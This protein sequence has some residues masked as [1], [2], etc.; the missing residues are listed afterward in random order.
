MCWQET[1]VATATKFA[2]SHPAAQTGKENKLVRKLTQPIREFFRHRTENWTTLSEIM[3][4]SMAVLV[5]I[6]TG[7]LAAILIWTLDLIGE[8]AFWLYSVITD[9]FGL[10]LGLA[11]GGLVVGYVV[12]RWAPEAGGHGVPEVIKSVALRGGYMRG[13]LAPIKLVLSSITIGMGGSAGRE[14]PIVQIGAAFGSWLGRRANFSGDRLRILV[15]CGSAAGISAVFNAPIAGAMF[16]LEVIVRRFTIANF[17]AVVLSAVFG[18]IVVSQVV[19]TQPAFPVPAYEFTHLGE[20]PIYAV[21]GLLAALWAALF[22]RVFTLGER[23]FASLKMPLALKAALGMVL[24]G[25]LA[26]LLPEREILG[27][28]LE[29]IG[30]TI[31]DN[32]VLPWQQLV[33]LLV[34]KMLATT[35]TLGSGNSGGV[36]APNLFM[37]AALGGLVGAGANML[38]PTVAVNPGAYAL[39]GMAAVLA[40]AERAPITG[41]LLVFEMSGDYQLILPLMLTTVLAA[42]TVELM[43]RGSI[44]TSELGLE[45]IRLRR[46]RDEAVLDSITVAEVMTPSLE[47]VPSNMTLEEFGRQLR[48]THH[49]GLPMIDDGRLT[50]VVTIGD[51]DRAM[52]NDLPGD[53]AVR[54][55]ATPR[56]RLIT[57]S[58]TDSIGE[59]MRL[60]GRNGFGRIP[61]VDQ[62]NPDTFLGMVR[63]EDVIN[64]YDIALTRRAELKKRAAETEARHP[65]SAVFVELT[66]TDE[67]AAC[68]QTIQRLAGCLPQDCVLVAVR[69]GGRLL[70]PHGDTRLQP[71]D[72]VTALV[73]EH[74]R[75]TLSE[76]LGQPVVSSDMVTG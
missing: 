10:L 62:E 15:A 25:L 56:S 27:S 21:L 23:T 34:L 11:A 63:R 20:L 41:I 54:E 30:E 12:E 67:C 52:Q 37:G 17:G 50:G 18:S 74:D 45:G 73:A 36:F 76:C 16:A 65:D 71:G 75:D 6:G 43:S 57:V 7:I 60:M 53:T 29:F 61:V 5:G 72:L 28:G 1:A 70:I 22:I 48:I 38:W 3:L 9:P 64:A 69:R 26:L 32:I 59:A 2:G 39:V 49:H 42:L 19:S 13:A 14:G 4:V 46:G 47:S 51:L 58:A 40:A 44:Y 35:I 33:A 8:F 24:T 31:S 55:I 68:G 66:I